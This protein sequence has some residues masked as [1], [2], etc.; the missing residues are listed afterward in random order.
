MDQVAE[1]LLAREP[2]LNRRD[3]G[4]KDYMGAEVRGDESRNMAQD[5]NPGNINELLREI[6]RHRP[7]SAQRQ[8]LEQELARI[9]D[10]ASNLLGPVQAEPLPGPRMGAQN[11]PFNPATQG[12]WMSPQ[13]PV[14]RPKYPY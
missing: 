5:L 7:G 10:Q 11:A 12:G 3:Q 2:R 8:I 13:I 9:K 6:D 14:V 4:L 1:M